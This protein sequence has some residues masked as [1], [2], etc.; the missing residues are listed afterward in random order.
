MGDFGG[1]QAF[2]QE[3]GGLER[4]SFQRTFQ[5]DSL[6]L[7]DWFAW[8]CGHGLAPDLRAWNEVGAKFNSAGPYLFQHEKKIPTTSSTK[9]QAIQGNPGF[10][11]TLCRCSVFQRVR[12]R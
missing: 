6:A 2:E 4:T 9:C 10:V 5:Q 8:V 11:G 12:R 1:M 7:S 3:P